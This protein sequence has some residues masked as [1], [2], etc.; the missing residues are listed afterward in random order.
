MSTSTKTIYIVW[1]SRCDA[2]W[3]AA[4]ENEV[5]EEGR[6]RDTFYGQ[7]PGCMK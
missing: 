7:D 3:L 5:D 1:R 4:A 6:G 2:E